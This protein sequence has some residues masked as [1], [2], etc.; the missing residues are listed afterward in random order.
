[1]A[2]SLTSELTDLPADQ[3]EGVTSNDACTLSA[4]PSESSTVTSAGA[5]LP[6]RPNRPSSTSPQLIGY[7]F[8]DS[9]HRYEDVEK[10]AVKKGGRASPVWTHGSELRSP[11]FRSVFWLCHRC[12]GRGDTQIL[13]GDKGCPE[14]QCQSCRPYGN[15][16]FPHLGSA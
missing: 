8:K 5:R 7:S 3:Q 10:S 1:M 14:R 11:S 16:T 9:G 15:T 12:W 2:Y 4:A 13:L 6:S